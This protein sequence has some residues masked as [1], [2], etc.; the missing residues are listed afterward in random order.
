MSETTQHTD[1]ENYDPEI[2]EIFV[3]EGAELVASIEMLYGQWRADPTNLKKAYEL[4]R[5]YH[6]MKG[7][8]RMAGVFRLGDLSYEMEHFYEKFANGTWVADE[9]AFALLEKCHAQTALMIQQLTDEQTC[10]FATHL[11]EA[12]QQFGK[13]PVEES[14]VEKPI[15]AEPTVA[16]SIAKD[17]SV[18]ETLPAMASE[19]ASNL[20]TAVSQV[21]EETTA[22]IEPTPIPETSVSI[23][24][25]VEIIDE[26]IFDQPP[27]INSTS[28]VVLS[29]SDENKIY[30]TGMLSTQSV[31]QAV[32]EELESVVNELNNPLSEEHIA[33]PAD[34][35]A[36]QQASAAADSAFDS[37]VESIEK[38]L[39][40]SV[41]NQIA[42]EHVA[43]DD[44]NT[45]SDVIVGDQLSPPPKPSIINAEENQWMDAMPCDETTASETLQPERKRMLAKAPRYTLTLRD[46]LTLSARCMIVLIFWQWVQN[47]LGGDLFFGQLEQGY[48]LNESTRLVIAEK[49]MLPMLSAASI[50]YLIVTSTGC[51]S[52]LILLGFLTRIGALGLLVTAV[53]YLWIFPENLIMCLLWFIV[54]L[55]LAKDGAGKLSI[56]H[57]IL[58]NIKKGR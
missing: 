7:G 4:Q 20:D 2:L 40:L 8:S 14:F 55:F 29:Q 32:I 22:R 30:Q 44:V 10:P 57:A 5:T 51:F 58:V 45:H 42:D 31:T 13:T 48:Q 50:G 35:L 49:I 37:E 12:I 24:A 54:L 25:I 47:H 41:N 27:P 33:T 43:A 46:G 16:A 34:E 17:N 36:I 39:E 28:S 38:W 18:A 56:D 21:F 26:P 9:P 15:G 11:I 52:L 1:E 19:S 6:T 23:A 53:I 3:E